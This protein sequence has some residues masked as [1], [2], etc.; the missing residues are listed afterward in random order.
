M[1]VEDFK[2]VFEKITKKAF[3]FLT[4]DYDFCFIETQTPGFGIFVTFRNSTTGVEI[5]YDIRDAYVDILIYP[6]IKGK[7]E[8]ASFEKEIHLDDVLK[9]KAIN[10]KLDHKVSGSTQMNEALELVLGRFAN[11]LKE[12]GQNVLCGVSP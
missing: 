10:I 5:W 1:P 6:L 7:K 4:D 3:S 9:F 2:A 12:Y 8:K 11:I